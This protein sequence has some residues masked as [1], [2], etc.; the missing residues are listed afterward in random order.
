MFAIVKLILTTNPLFILLK[1]WSENITEGGR[2]VHFAN[3]SG[4]GTQISPNTNYQ[5]TKMSEIRIQ[6]GFKKYVGGY[7]DFANPG[8]GRS[9]QILPILGGEQP[10]F[11]N[12]NQKAST[13]QQCFLK[14]LTLKLVSKDLVFHS[15]RVFI[16]CNNVPDIG[17]YKS[18][19]FMRPF[20][21]N[22]Q[23][24]DCGVT[25]FLLLRIL[26]SSYVSV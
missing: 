4:E 23:V 8:E 21:L 22:Q 24:Q 25:T 19:K 14:S 6:S 17:P 3:L 16:S 20:L 18:S 1:D 7:R 26:S 12:K 9:T 13:L 2:L 10:D 11:T 5:K 15:L